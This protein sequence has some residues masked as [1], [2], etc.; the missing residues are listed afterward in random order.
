M[1]RGLINVL[2]IVAFF[3]SVS[4]SEAY[5]SN[6]RF[7]EMKNTT[8]TSKIAG[9]VRLYDEFPGLKNFPVEKDDL[10]YE[11]MYEY[12]E[13]I[14]YWQL[15]AVYMPAPNDDR[16]DYLIS[17]Q[18]NLILKDSIYRIGTGAMKTYVKTADDKYWTDLHWQMILG[19]GFPIGNHFSIDIYAHYVYTN[20]KEITDT[21]MAAIDYSVLLSVSF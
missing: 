20:W 17:P 11:L 1:K 19:L 21:D 3:V 4:S 7:G 6:S 9:G 15:G 2:V 10:G 12:H 16:F 5:K 18:I 8:S 14:G 13:G